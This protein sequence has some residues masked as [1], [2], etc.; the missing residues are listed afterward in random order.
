MT[1]VHLPK[2]EIKGEDLEKAC[3]KAAGELEYRVDSK[4]TYEKEYSLEPFKR[5]K[6]YQYTDLT[7]V[8]NK[9][10][11]FTIKRIKRGVTLKCFDISPIDIIPEEVIEQY[12]ERV[13]KYL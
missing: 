7:M 9:T 11:F 12:L 1:I 2:K 8:K 10:P 6:I 4:D 13:S 3:L 5:E